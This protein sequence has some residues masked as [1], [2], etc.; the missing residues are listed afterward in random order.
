MQQTNLMDIPKKECFKLMTSSGTTGQTVS[1]VYLDKATALLPQKVLLR[2]LSD[3]VGKK[4]LPM[5][6]V[7][8]PEVLKDRKL[9]LERTVPGRMADPEEVANVVYFLAG[10][11]ASFVNGQIVKVNGGINFDNVKS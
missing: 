1:R 5:M 3:L 10:D 6:F 7:D 8:S 2:I 4:R 9:F 11:E